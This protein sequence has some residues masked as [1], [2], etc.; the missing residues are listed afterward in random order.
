M[1]EIA[2]YDIESDYTPYKVALYPER[3]EVWVV[4][5][6]RRTG[7]RYMQSIKLGSDTYW[8]VLRDL[9]NRAEPGS[10]AAEELAQCADTAGA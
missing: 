4:K 10:L 3:A 2:H 6:N 1:P 7:E 5:R 9:K 8:R